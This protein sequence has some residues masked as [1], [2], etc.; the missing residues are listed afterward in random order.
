MSRSN[1]NME[2]KTNRVNDR[3][4][5]EKTIPRAAKDYAR[6]LKIPLRPRLNNKIVSWGLLVQLGEVEYVYSLLAV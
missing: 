4:R 3:R 5:R 2:V 6:Q 1:A